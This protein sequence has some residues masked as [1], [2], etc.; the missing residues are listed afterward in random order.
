M[1]NVLENLFGFAVVAAI[2]ALFAFGFVWGLEREEKLIQE[3]CRHLSGY[4][5]GECEMR[6]R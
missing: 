1:K 5:Y 3:H 2:S 4:A 6:V